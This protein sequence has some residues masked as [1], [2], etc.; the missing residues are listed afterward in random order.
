MVW[1]PVDIDF[2]CT[3]GSLDVVP[4]ESSTRTLFLRV[5]DTFL[6]LIL[7]HIVHMEENIHDNTNLSRIIKYY[8]HNYV[9]LPLNS[10]YTSKIGQT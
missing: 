3:M 2:V 7:I 8:S 9:R 4:G 6:I 10:K 5:M 1:V